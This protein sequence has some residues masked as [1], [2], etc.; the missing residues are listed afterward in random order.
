MKKS[1]LLGAVC[2]S[3]AAVSFNTSAVHLEWCKFLLLVMLTVLVP[4]HFAVAASPGDVVI[5]EIMQNPSAVSDSAGEWFELFNPTGSAIDINGWT[6][7]DND[8]DSH[9]MKFSSK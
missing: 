5:N 8:F 3:Q 7:Q 1:R 2:A 6:I 9:V 4:G